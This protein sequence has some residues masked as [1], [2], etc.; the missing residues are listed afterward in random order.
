[1]YATKY[2]VPAAGHG[3]APANTIA[4]AA[5]GMPETMTERHRRLLKEQD[6]QLRILKDLVDDMREMNANALRE[7]GGV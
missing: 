7:L 4:R 1:M 6:A 3:A 5:C 2:E